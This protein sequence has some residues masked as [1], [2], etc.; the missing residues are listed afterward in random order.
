M[1]GKGKG[2]ERGRKEEG[3]PEKPTAIGNFDKYLTGKKDIP[4]KNLGEFVQTI[5]QIPGTPNIKLEFK[6]PQEIGHGKNPSLSTVVE[7]GDF[8]QNYSDQINRVLP[9]INQ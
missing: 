4:Y 7:L 2:K 6:D 8:I 3:R 9:Q 1:F 5:E